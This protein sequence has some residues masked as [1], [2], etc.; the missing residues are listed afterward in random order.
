MPRPI[1][2]KPVLQSI[3]IFL[4]P[5]ILVKAAAFILGAPGPRQSSA[6]IAADAQPALAINAIAAPATVTQQQQET[7]QRIDDLRSLPFGDSPLYYP[8]AE[9]A[10]VQ[11]AVET[12]SIGPAPAPAFTVQAILVRSTGNLAL[13]NQRSYTVGDTL[14]QSDWVVS[15][16][17]GDTHSV[18]ITQPATGR[19]AT[20]T[21]Q[22]PG[23]RQTDS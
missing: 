21:Q 8:P 15:E 9:A 11:S 17:N 20:R 19:T 3:G 6:A 1:D 5:V 22:L 4:L 16:I 10:P 13:I 23:A 18:T 12:V 14:H 7:L 2:P